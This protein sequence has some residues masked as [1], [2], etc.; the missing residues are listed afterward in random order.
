MDRINKLRE[1]LK[2][3]PNDSFLR[4]ALA[5]E[6]IKIGNDDEARKLFESILNDDPKYVGSYY[7]LARLLER[8]GENELAI[9][10]YERGM[11]TAKEAGD[12]HS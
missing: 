4:H 8:V 12:Q 1:Y 10:W 6:Y 11:E 2:T 9:K 3:A 5:L 7:H